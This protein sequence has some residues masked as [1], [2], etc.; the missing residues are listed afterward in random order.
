MTYAVTAQIVRLVRKLLSREPGAF[1]SELALQRFILGALHAATNSPC[2]LRSATAAALF[3][4]AL[5][6]NVPYLQTNSQGCV[7]SKKAYQL[8]LHLYCAAQA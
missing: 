4:A 1:Y 5:S 3:V 2:K 7:R 6:W 8:E